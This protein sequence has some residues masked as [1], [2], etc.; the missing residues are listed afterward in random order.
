VAAATN[1]GG[2]YYARTVLISK[3]S[4]LLYYS[5]WIND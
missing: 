3:Q 1:A 5:E 2:R 4:N